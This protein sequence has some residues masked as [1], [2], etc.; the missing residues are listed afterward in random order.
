MKIVSELQTWS[1]IG[2]HF[3]D[4][5]VSSLL[6]FVEHSLLVSVVNTLTLINLSA[7]LVKKKFKLFPSIVWKLTC[8]PKKSSG[9]D[10]LDLKTLAQG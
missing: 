8:L 7:I 2:S 10:C 4:P 1:F 5:V 6:A 3:D 9:C